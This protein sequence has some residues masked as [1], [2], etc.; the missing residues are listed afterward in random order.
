MDKYYCRNPVYNKSENWPLYNRN[1]PQYFIWNG[2]IRGKHGGGD[3]QVRTR[4]CQVLGRDQE[5]Q[6]VLSGMSL[7]QCCGMRIEQ[8]AYFW[9]DSL[10][11]IQFSVTVRCARSE[12]KVVTGGS[13]SQQPFIL[14]VIFSFLFLF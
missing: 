8:V 7:C 10:I 6:P 13:S 11:I 5:L 1:E 4:H 2:N 12:S 9:S 14:P 3:G